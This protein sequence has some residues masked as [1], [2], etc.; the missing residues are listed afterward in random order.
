[1]AFDTDIYFISQLSETETSKRHRN[2]D[3]VSFPIWRRRCQKKG[4]E[5]LDLAV[6]DVLMDINMYYSKCC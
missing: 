4:N 3:M 2:C 6:N 5:H 1:M